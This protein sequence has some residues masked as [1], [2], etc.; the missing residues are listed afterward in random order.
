MAR[1]AG[2]DG[3]P[4]PQGFRSRP[5]Y[6]QIRLA[7]AV[8]LTTPTVATTLAGANLAAPAN[9]ADPLPA[10]G[11][12][13]V[14][15]TL[16]TITAPRAMMLEVEYGLS[17]LTVVNGQ[18][19]TAEVYVGAVANGGKSSQTQLTAAPASLNGKTIVNVAA[20]D[21]ITVKV[22]ASTGNFVAD[23]GFVVVKEV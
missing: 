8:T 15:A 14:A 11:G 12:L 19:L 18:V 17:N 10:D 20:G 16:G 6:A 2:S 23:T 21:V 22:T 7:G 1:V 5:A 3:L 4:V 13:V 9:T